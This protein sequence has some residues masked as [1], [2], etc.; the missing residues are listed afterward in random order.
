MIPRLRIMLSYWTITCKWPFSVNLTEE[1]SVYC[2]N[3]ITEGDNYYTALYNPGVVN[4][5]YHRFTCYVSHPLYND[6]LSH[7]FYT[8]EKLKYWTCTL[9]IF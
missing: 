8:K 4:T 3:T 6:I 2:V 9:E 7:V 5:V 1:G